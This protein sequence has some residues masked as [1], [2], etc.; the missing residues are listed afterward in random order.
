MVVEEFGDIER[1]ALL[2]IGLEMGSAIAKEGKEFDSFFDLFSREV[3]V[4]ALESFFYFSSPFVIII[5]P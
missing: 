4:K 3:V 1:E 5:I 2:K